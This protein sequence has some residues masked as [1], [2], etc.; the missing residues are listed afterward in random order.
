MKNSSVYFSPVINNEPVDSVCRKMELLYKKAGFD[1]LVKKND[2]VALKMH[3][4]EE[5]K[6]PSVLPAYV[7]RIAELVRESGGK[8]FVTDTNTLYEGPR[9]NAVDHLAL[10][11]KNGL[12]LEQLDCPVIIAD[13]LIGEN[14]I[15]VPSTH[16]FVHIA[17]LV[18]RVDVILALTHC[19]GHLLTG[20]GG[21]IK[22]IAMGFAGR[23]GKLDQHS[24]IKPVIVEEDCRGCKV[25]A[26]YCPAKSITVENRKA[27]IKP[28]DCFG[29]GECFALCPNKAV[30]VNKWAASSEGA[31]KKMAMYCTEI[32]KDKKAGFINFAINI[33]KSC[34]CIGH[35][36]E[37]ALVNDVGIFTS[38]DIVAVETASINM[39]NETAQKDVF[40]EAWPEIDYTIQFS[41]G[42]KLG[43]GSP[44]YTLD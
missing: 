7:K 8:P 20:Y 16:G 5:K 25:C 19:T 15:S 31:Q 14:Q 23:G 30:K 34:D 2:L 33:T 37:K 26:N 3:F 29:C 41:E 18:K 1:K 28:E 32:L 39:I 12:S 21:A 43:M 9:M 10:A 44:R 13:G 22:N 6:K 4:G 38:A 27:H 42:E 36:G 35:S 11:N 17:G 40:K 24:G